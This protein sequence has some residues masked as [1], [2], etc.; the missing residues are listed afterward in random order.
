MQDTEFPGWQ[1][2]GGVTAFLN[3]RDRYRFIAFGDQ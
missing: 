3:I 1:I 2:L